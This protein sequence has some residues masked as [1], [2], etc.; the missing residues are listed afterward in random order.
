VQQYRR[1]RPYRRYPY[2]LAPRAASDQH[3][4]VFHRGNAR[5]VSH[6][7]R[8]G[9]NLCL[10]LPLLP[11]LLAQANVV[12]SERGWASR[13]VGTAADVRTAA[14]YAYATACSTAA[15]AA[16]MHGTSAQ[17]RIAYRPS[18]PKTR[19]EPSHTTCSEQGQL[20][21]PQSRMQLRGVLIPLINTTTI[22]FYF[23]KEKLFVRF[24]VFCWGSTTR[25]KGGR[26]LLK[27]IDICRIW[28]GAAGFRSLHI[29]WA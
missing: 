18:A 4:A 6:R 11:W 19:Q 8:V 28:Q 23:F 2:L 20:P 9:R 24:F 22:S 26:A 12:T 29:S 15:S 5:R 27:G 16:H 14:S 25:V 10:L 7:A 13:I 3:V 1:Q 21:A 17:T